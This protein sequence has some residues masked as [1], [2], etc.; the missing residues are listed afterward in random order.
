MRWKNLQSPPISSAQVSWLFHYVEEGADT[1]DILI[2]E[3]LKIEEFDT[4]ETLYIRA[5][6][7]AMN[8]FSSA[9]DKV[10]SGQRGSK[11]EGISSYYP[12]GCPHKGEINPSWDQSYKERFIRAMIY[13][14]Y[15]VAKLGEK[16]I[17][18]IQD[19]ETGQHQVGHE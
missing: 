1:G 2:Q 13:A 8:K 18:K 6:F 16:D 10:V 11:Q 5:M 3:K 4:Q 19:L 7:E 15:P 12:R 9:F 14:P 17:F